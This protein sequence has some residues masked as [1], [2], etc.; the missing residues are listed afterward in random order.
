[1]RR[2]SAVNLGL[3]KGLAIGTQDGGCRR[4]HIALGLTVLW[5]SSMGAGLIVGQM[6]GGA[7]HVGL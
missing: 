7:I 5:K 2:K 3:G 6:L 1:M 4:L